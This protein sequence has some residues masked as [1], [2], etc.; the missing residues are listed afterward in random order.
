[1]FLVGQKGKPARFFSVESTFG[2]ILSE[3]RRERG[4]SQEELGFKSNYH[5]TY[6]SLLER[7]QRSPSLRTIFRLAAA[8]EV[9]PSDMIQ[10]IED[11]T[12]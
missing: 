9:R 11:E 12:V 3:I 1:M 6:I 2:H 5:R 4:L 7:G 8:L 10:R